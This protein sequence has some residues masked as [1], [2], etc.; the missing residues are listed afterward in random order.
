MKGPCVGN[1][2]AISAIGFPQLCLQDG[3]LGIRYAQQVTAFP[4]GIQTG[5]TWDTNLMY[6]RGLALGQESKGLGVHVLL[7]PVA[8]PLGKIPNAGRNWEGFAAD[9]YLSGIATGL[10]VEGMQAGGV[11]AC[12]KHYI[13]NEQE[14]NRGTINSVIDDRSLH[15]LY[16]WPFADAVKANVTSVMCAYNKFDGSW[17]CESNKAL[18]QILKTELDFQGYVVSDWG[19][20]QQTTAGSANAGMDMSMPG[21]NFGDNKFLWG[22]ALSSAISSGTVPQSRLDDMCKRILAAWYFV[23]QDTGYPTVTG[24][25]SWNGGKGGPNVQGTHSTIARAIARDGIVLL[26]NTN[27]ALPLKKPASLAIIGQ[28]AI[29]NPGGAN[30]CQDRGC[31]TGTLAMVS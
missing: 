6:A 9:P 29:V 25:T 7:G 30:S 14:T 15:E 21:D 11:Q 5:S 16:L 26:K 19:T 13:G 31:D 20:A 8:G 23:G 4:S 3:P 24:W 10:T 17:S 27:N 18:T 2:A 28:D 12:V 1:L 22:T